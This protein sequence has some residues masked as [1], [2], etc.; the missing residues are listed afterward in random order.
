VRI[1]QKPFDPEQLLDA[2]KLHARRPA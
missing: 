1:F 2:I